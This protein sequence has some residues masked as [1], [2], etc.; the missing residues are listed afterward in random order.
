[1]GYA[2]SRKWKTRSGYR[3]AAE[4]TVYVAP[5]HARGDLFAVQFHPEKSQKVG[6]ALLDRFVRL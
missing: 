1:M 6:L 4:V 2:S 3:F 5:G